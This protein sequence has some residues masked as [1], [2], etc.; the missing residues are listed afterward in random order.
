MRRK[1]TVIGLCVVLSFSM[2]ACSGTE[3]KKPENNSTT[4]NVSVDNESSSDKEETTTND[5]T[6]LESIE[7]TSSEEG[8]T[9]EVVVSETTKQSETTKT[10]NNKNNNSSGNKNNTGSTG[11]NTSGGNT[12][13][14]NT[15]GGSTSND[16][17]NDNYKILHNYEVLGS[18]YNK[19]KNAYKSGST[20]GLSGDEIT[21]YNRLKECLDQ[22]N[23]KSTK[24]EKEKAVHDWIILNCEYDE[25]NY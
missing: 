17:D 15:T 22:A 24:V 23:S 5:E 12:S 11:G 7:E 1:I 6:T 13:G 16:D 10:Q 14:G 20:S 9:T 19:Y 4:I 18:R 8:I 3:D 2:T 21:F 25:E